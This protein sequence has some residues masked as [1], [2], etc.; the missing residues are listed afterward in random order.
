MSDIQVSDLL[1]KI[2]PIGLKIEEAMFHVT[3][4]INT[5]KG[6][7]FLMGVVCAATSKSIL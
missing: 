3:N 1:N 4:N 7:I 5:H 6:L 2:R